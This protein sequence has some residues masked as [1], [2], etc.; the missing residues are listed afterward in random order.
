MLE[1]CFKCGCFPGQTCSN[2]GICTGDIELGAGAEEKIEE[3]VSGFRVILDL[4]ELF[5]NTYENWHETRYNPDEFLPL[6]KKAFH[7]LP[8]YD[9]MPDDWYEGYLVITDY[10]SGMADRFALAKFEKLSSIN[11]NVGRA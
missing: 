6:Y 4:L 11:V 5:M 3:E 9:K 7:L 1:N 10:V 8:G 2:E